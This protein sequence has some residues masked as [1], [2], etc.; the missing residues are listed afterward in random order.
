VCAIYVKREREHKEMNSYE[1]PTLTD[2]KEKSEVQRLLA[3]LDSNPC[4]KSLS[5]KERALSLVFVGNICKVC[6]TTERYV[7]SKSCK[8]C[9]QIKSRL[10]NE[11]RKKQTAKLK[12]KK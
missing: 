3:R 6:G 12:Q 4:Y 1:F 11:R 7:V 10:K 8:K 5:G 9:L 2:S